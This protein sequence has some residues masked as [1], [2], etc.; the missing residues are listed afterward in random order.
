MQLDG[1]VSEV[2]KADASA[3]L[4]LRERRGDDVGGQL[5]LFDQCVHRP[6]AATT[7]GV[8]QPR[9]GVVRR[10]PTLGRRLVVAADRKLCEAAL[11]DEGT[12]FGVTKAE[13]AFGVAAELELAVMQEVMVGGACYE[14]AG[15]RCLVG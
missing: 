9:G 5:E 10:R 11:A 14:S 1:M 15:H 12:A 8:Q 7:D 4:Q 13:L 2:A 6:S 3:Q